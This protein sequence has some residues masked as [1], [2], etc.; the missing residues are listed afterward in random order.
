MSA[1]IRLTAPTRDVLGI[2][3]E[4]AA[5]STPTY[6]LEI[7]LATGHGSGTVYP[8]LRRLE[9][10]GWVRSYWDESDTTGPRR[11]LLEMT[12]EGRTAA[13]EALANRGTKPAGQWR[14]SPA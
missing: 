14:W 12:A 9:G 3:L 5:Q 10:I 6:G 8:I 13:Q 2:L 1:P 4:A 11:R 7:C